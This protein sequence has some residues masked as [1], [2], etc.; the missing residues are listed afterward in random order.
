MNVHLFNVCRAANKQTYLQR[1]EMS[2]S[3]ILYSIHEQS[4]LN[5][6]MK[7]INLANLVYD[8]SISW[9]KRFLT[10][11]R[12]RFVFKLKTFINDFRGKSLHN[13]IK[14]IFPLKSFRKLK[15]KIS[16]SH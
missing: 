3:I 4:N 16:N 14:K 13:I 7:N 15:S 1:W 12:L 9:N 8:G 10:L 2:Y 6:L 5:S 11:Y